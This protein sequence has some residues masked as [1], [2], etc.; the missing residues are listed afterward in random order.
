RH[1]KRQVPF[2]AENGTPR[3]MDLCSRWA[4][5][6]MRV[7]RGVDRTRRTAREGI[8]RHI[9]TIAS[10]ASSALP[11]FSGEEIF[12]RVGYASVIR[13]IQRE[14]RAGLDPSADSPRSVVQTSRGQFLLMP[15]EVGG[16]A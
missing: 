11:W 3:L 4:H 14:L 12:Q 7:E 13:A 6:A 1:E 8:E 10:P 2:Y 9:V 16:A 5:P 15:A